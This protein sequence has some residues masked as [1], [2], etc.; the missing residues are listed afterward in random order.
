MQIYEFECKKCWH[1]FERLLTRAE[2]DKAQECPSCGK[3]EGD[4]VMS[5]SSVSV[6]GGG[7][8]GCGPTGFS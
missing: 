6:Q 2:S 4:R 7:S 5:A 8:S 1:R 3:A